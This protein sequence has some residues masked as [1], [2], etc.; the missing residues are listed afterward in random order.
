MSNKTILIMVCILVGG[1]IGLISSAVYVN[2]SKKAL[3]KQHAVLD[4]KCQEYGR[5]MGYDVD[6]SESGT[7]FV[8][9]D[10]GVTLPVEQALDLQSDI[11][12]H[13]Q[14]MGINRQLGGKK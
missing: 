11:F 13:R 2:E 1:I 4:M 12:R 10:Y 3:A 6:F 5:H 8:T 7:C 9:M 14:L